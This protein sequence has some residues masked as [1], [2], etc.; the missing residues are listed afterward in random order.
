MQDRYKTKLVPYPAPL[1]LVYWQLANL[2]RYKM[3]DRYKTQLVPYPAPLLLVYWQLAILSRL[4]FIG[5]HLVTTASSWVGNGFWRL[6]V[7]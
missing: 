7:Q 5:G 2:N 6:V 1:L 3:Q 4:E